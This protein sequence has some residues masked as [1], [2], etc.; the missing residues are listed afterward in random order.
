[1]DVVAKRTGDT[2]TVA[3][4]RPGSRNALR[5]ATLAEL[6]SA[7]DTAELDPD[8]RA[9]VLTGGPEFFCAGVDLKEV[10]A[11]DPAHDA[12]AGTARL[13]RV[14]RLVDRLRTFP[15]PTLAAVEGYAIGIGF[16]LVLSCD[17]VTASR[18]AFFA[19][20]AAQAGM[21][22][23]GGL[24][25]DLYRL[26][27]YRRALELLLRRRRI[28]AE[29]ALAYGLVTELT[30]PGGS[31]VAA[32]AVVRDFA[33]VPPEVLFGLKGLA[34]SA[35]GAD[36]LAHESTAVALLKRTTS[37]EARRRFLAGERFFEE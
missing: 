26:V 14:H 10:T 3:I 4:D 31:L 28:S 8:V 23:D 13:R 33:D 17:L 30:E 37:A 15:K 24:V 5:T 21:L 18:T 1:V 35:S 6:E 22:A 27:G 19:H 25:R 36:F 11:R 12:A 29:E 16:A 34:A 9:V 20:P 2:L 7:L 32:E